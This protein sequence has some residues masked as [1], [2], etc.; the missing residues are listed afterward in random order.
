MNSLIQECQIALHARRFIIEAVR[1]DYKSRFTDSMLGALWMILNPLALVA[2]YTFVLSIILAA[3]LPGIAHAYAY[4]VYLI[5]GLIGWTLFSE[6]LMRSS[7]VFCEFSPLFK[8][9]TVPVLAYFCIVIVTGYVNAFLLWLA[10]LAILFLLGFPVTKWIL[11]VPLLLGLTALFGAGLGAVLS[12]FQVFA[13][14]IS[15]ALPILVQLLFWL[16]PIVYTFEMIPADIARFAIYHPFAPLIGL[17]HNT[18][19]YGEPP[20]AAYLLVYASVTTAIWWMFLRVY[21]RAESELLDA[22]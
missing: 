3:K 22:L 12:V 14:D 13:K 7:Q 8:K 21:S 19:A 2:L 18:I 10:S 17:F 4:P 5:S 1:A 6:V 20:N 9:T 15:Q 16:T 11:L